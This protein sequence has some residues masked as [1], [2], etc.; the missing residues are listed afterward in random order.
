MKM[1]IVHCKTNQALAVLGDQ[2]YW[3]F[4]IFLLNI[5]LNLGEC[6]AGLNVIKWVSVSVV[7]LNLE[8][9]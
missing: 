1:L 4:H 2:V 9:C 3:Y 8:V 5:T 7:V 6:V